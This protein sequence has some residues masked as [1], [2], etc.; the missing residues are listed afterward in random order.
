MDEAERY[1]TERL[2]ETVTGLLAAYYEVLDAKLLAD[3]A[4]RKAARMT[5]ER[6]REPRQILPRLGIVE[7][8]RRIMRKKM[9]H[10]AI[11]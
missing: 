3:K 8:E 7:Y 9:E 10:T 5:V 6:R 4:G 2:S 11:R 1:F